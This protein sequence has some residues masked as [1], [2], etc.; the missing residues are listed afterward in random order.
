MG[1]GRLFPHLSPLVLPGTTG[2]PLFA[3]GA[4][5]GGGGKGVHLSH[6]HVLPS[7]TSIWYHHCR[8]TGAEEEKKK[9]TE[10]RRK[11]HRVEHER[12]RFF[13]FFFFLLFRF[14][15]VVVI[16]IIVGLDTRAPH[17]TKNKKKQCGKEEEIPFS[18]RLPPWWWSLPASKSVWV[19][20]RKPTVLA[21]DTCGAAVS[22]NRECAGF[23]LCIFA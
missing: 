14:F 11:Q 21:L 23:T 7:S 18:I 12:W 15:F 17:H 5:G 10:E 20:W 3:D 2:C 8:P 9:K 19:G 4:D 13:A 6:A 1:T 22:R 16:I